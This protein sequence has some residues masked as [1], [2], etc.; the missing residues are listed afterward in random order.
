MMRSEISS[1]DL[2]TSKMSTSEDN[3]LNIWVA[4]LSFHSLQ[5]QCAHGQIKVICTKM[6]KPTEMNTGYALMKVM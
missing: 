3:Y 1:S 5:I 6:V 4:L 2:F